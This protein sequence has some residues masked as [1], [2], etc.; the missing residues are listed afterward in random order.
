MNVKQWMA[1]TTDYEREAVASKAGTSVG[2]LWQLSGSHRQPS[3]KKAKALHQASLEVTP[4][5]VMDPHLL[6]FGSDSESRASA[7]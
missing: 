4:D 6:V 5:R 2:Y 3:P 1:S 7:A